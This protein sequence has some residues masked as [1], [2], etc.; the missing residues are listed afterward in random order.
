MASAQA[1]VDRAGHTGVVVTRKEQA[2]QSRSKLIDVARRL[3][4]EQGYGATSVS[5]ILSEAEMARG[6][7]YHH[8]P[9]GKKSLFGAVVDVV[10]HQLHEGFDQI[11]ATVDSPT[12]QILAGI[13]LVLELATD[14]DFGRIILIEAATVMPGAWA[15]GSEY[16]LLRHNLSLAMEQGEIRGL[17]LDATASIIYGAAR[18]SADY[19]A[20]SP[21][22]A[23]SAAEAK[24]VLRA[25]VEGLRP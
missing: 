12:E 6:A 23:Q 2:E 25:I 7:L 16:M 24:D 9:D 22:P 20:R 4:V 1:M 13:D 21:E 14:R 19:V 17:P 11:L 15:E 5:Q 3:F 18:R 8:F 10:D